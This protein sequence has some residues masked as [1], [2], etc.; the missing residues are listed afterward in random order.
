MELPEGIEAIED[1]AFYQCS[2]T[3]MNFPASLKHIGWRAFYKTNL[4]PYYIKERSRKT[5]N[6]I[7]FNYRKFNDQPIKILGKTA[8]GPQA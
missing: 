7:I 4:A 3:M 8:I 1:A 2:V 6:G 5:K